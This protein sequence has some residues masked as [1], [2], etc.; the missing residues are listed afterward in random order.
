MNAC[1]PAGV[2]NDG[3]LCYSRPVSECINLM[4]PGIHP[5]YHAKAKVSCACGNTF[6]TGSTEEEIS[7]ELCSKCHPFYTGKQKLVDTGR[8]VEK[9]RAKKAS[10]EKGAKTGKKVKREKRAT[11]KAVKAKKSEK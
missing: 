5:T 7:V 1:A 9:F 6:T 11:Q 10:A 2:A 4:K 3:P 8:R